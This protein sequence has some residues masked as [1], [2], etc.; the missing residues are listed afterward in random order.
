MIT[1]AQV[2]LLTIF[3]FVLPCTKLCI[4]TGRISTQ[5]HLANGYKI[6][7]LTINFHR[8]IQEQTAELVEVLDRLGKLK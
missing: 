6:H 7:Q 1:P 4:P 3:I 5:A 8:T 2:L